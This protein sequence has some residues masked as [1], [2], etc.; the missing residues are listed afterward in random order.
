MSIFKHFLLI[1][2]KFSARL[3]WDYKAKMSEKV[4]ATK[5]GFGR[6]VDHKMELVS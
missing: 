2:D 1:F 5:S 3:L 4:R 6:D